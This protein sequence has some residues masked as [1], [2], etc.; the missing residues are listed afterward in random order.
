MFINQAQG[1]VAEEVSVED[2]IFCSVK[3]V[4]VVDTIEL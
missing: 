2:V 4:A 3:P 1:V